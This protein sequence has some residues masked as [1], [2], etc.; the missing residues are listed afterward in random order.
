MRRAL[1]MLLMIGLILLSAGCRC[2]RNAPAQAP[3]SAADDPTL[4]PT[5]AG[6]AALEPA[7]ADVSSPTEFS[8]GGEGLE[9]PE[10]PIG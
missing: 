8:W 5:L 3:E 7:L 10:I 1:G 4:E 9:L 6:A 2:G